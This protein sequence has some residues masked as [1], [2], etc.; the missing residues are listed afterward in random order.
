MSKNDI[1]KYIKQLKQCETIKESEAIYLCESAKEILSEES[2]V[3]N[4][5]APVTI[6]GDIHGQF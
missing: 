1:D 4:I 6:C 3:Q 2:N 5:D